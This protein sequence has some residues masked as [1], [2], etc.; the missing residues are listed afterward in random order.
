MLESEEGTVI[1]L[2]KVLVQL[3]L[4]VLAEES[5][6]ECKAE[7]TQAA[8]ELWSIFKSF[9]AQCAGKAGTLHPG[10]A[11]PVCQVPPTPAKR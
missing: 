2:L 6:N 7:T 3:A 10:Q 4:S 1:P 5:L 8:R 11:V 9:I